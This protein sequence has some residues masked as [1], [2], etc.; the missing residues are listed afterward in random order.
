[1]GVML[2]GVALQPLQALGLVINTAGTYVCVRV[3]M[4]I[5]ILQDHVL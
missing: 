5:Q 4:C 2:F 1:M 3:Y